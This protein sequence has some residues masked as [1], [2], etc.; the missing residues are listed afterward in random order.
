MSSLPRAWPAEHLPCR[1]PYHQQGFPG[2]PSA[3]RRPLTT[4]SPC[5]VVEELSL[6][7]LFSHLS[8]RRLWR[9]DGFGWDPKVLK[10]PSPS[11]GLIWLAAGFQQA[12]GLDSGRPTSHRHDTFTSRKDEVP[13]FFGIRGKCAAGPSSSI[14]ASPSPVSSSPRSRR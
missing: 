14:G 1:L 3:V 11:H 2:W 7:P 6:D 4:L 13:L 10:N 9:G 8:P 5:L 12:G